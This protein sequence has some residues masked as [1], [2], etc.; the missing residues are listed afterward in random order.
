[1]SSESL[2]EERFWAVLRNFVDW[3]KRRGGAYALIVETA[4]IVETV[5]R[6]N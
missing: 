3:E 4:T 6:R 5:T 2:R 1:M